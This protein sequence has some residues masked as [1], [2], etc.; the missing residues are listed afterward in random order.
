MSEQHI[1]D[2]TGK[3]VLI[4]GG[5]RGLGRAMALGFA[6]AGADI[7]VASRRIE[8]CEE[9]VRAVE[10]LGRRAMAH[11][12]H[13]GRWHECDALVDAAYARFGKVDVLINNAGKSP[14]YD[15]PVDID[16][17]LYDSVL[18]LNLKGPFRLIAV[19]GQRTMDAGG[20]AIIN[21]SSIGSIRARKNIITYAAAKA[22]RNAMTEAFADSYGPTVR[23][24][25]ILPGPF[26]T[27][28]SKAWDMEAFSKRAETSIAMKRGGQPE[29]V[30]ASAHY[31]ASDHASYATGAL[32][33]IDGGSH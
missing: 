19:I 6:E 5:S 30:V 24:N 8:F 14:L 13:A 1:I 7:V 3:V 33:R 20:G 22:G 21:I 11:A 4:T 18:D 10:N 31:L 23:V 26:L 9:V 17:T 27:D 2:M 29:E 12:C 25:A 16:E 15:R 32:L 28:I